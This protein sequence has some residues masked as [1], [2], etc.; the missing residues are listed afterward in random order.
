MP[1]VSA[2][3]R[4]RYYNAGLQRFVSEDPLDGLVIVNSYSYASDEPIDRADPSGLTDL[5]YINGDNTLTVI[6]GNGKIVGMYP[7]FNNAAL[8]SAGPYG[9]RLSI[10]WAYYSPRRWP[11]SGKS[12][13]S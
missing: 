4:A 12:V 13:W 1:T 3:D 10:R 9:G 11:G 8:G 6:D 2:F 5:V 7:A